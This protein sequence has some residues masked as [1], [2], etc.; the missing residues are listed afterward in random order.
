MKLSNQN[1]INRLEPCLCGCKG[2][3]P[4]HARNFKRTVTVDLDDLTVG[5]ARF[6]WGIEE[7]VRYRY[8]SNGKTVFGAWERSE[9]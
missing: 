9:A 7:V 8:E 2:K 4:W 6:P 3:D 5:F 1:I